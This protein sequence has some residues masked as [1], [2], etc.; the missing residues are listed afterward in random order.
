MTTPKRVFVIAMACTLLLCACACTAAQSTAAPKPAA[1]SENGFPMSDM[2][3][4][5][6]LEG[7]ASDLQFYDLTV[8][9]IERLMAD[10]K[11]FA[12]VAAFASCPWCNL[13]ITQLNDAALAEGVQVGY[14]N[15]RLN[16]DW[17]SNIDIDDYDTFV[18]LFGNYLKADENG[19]PH[20]YTPHVFVVKDGVVAGEH[21][22]GLGGEDN[23]SQPLTEEQSQAL[24]KLYRDELAKIR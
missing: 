5:A 4:Y 9:D 16:S 19:I 10:G 12:F 13:C 7:Y 17:K 8:K 21:E 22:G 11:S 3:G 2:S 6:A 14:L 20:L 1:T 15:T 23:P 18:A 24:V